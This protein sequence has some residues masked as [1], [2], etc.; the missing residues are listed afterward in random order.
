MK[1]TVRR[2]PFYASLFCHNIALKSISVGKPWDTEP[3]DPG[4]G[5]CSVTDWPC[6]NKMDKGQ[7]FS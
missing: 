5:S 2:E 4:W 7:N 1:V 3:G 6:D